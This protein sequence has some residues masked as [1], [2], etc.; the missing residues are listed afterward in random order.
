M[1][2]SL[3]VGV[4]IVVSSCG[5]ELEEGGETSGGMPGL[6]F[7]DTLAAIGSGQDSTDALFR[8]RG[9]AILAD[10]GF[11][12]ATD[13]DPGV[14]FYSDTG[15]L[16]DR[17]GAR[18]LGPA[19]IRTL[20][21]AGLR[22][23]DSV[24]VY[25]AGALRLM[26]FAQDGAFDRSLD[27]PDAGLRGRQPVWFK[28]LEES[29]LLA[30]STGLPEAAMYENQPAR[31]TVR[32]VRLELDGSSSE[33]LAAVANRWWERLPVEGSFSMRADIEGP[34]AVVTAGDSVI[35]LSDN[36]SHTVQ[37]ITIGSRHLPSLTLRFLSERPRATD[38]PEDRGGYYIY[39]MFVDDLGRLW[40]GSSAL[41][42]DGSRRWFVLDRTGEVAGRIDL[43]ETMRM[44]DIN[45][46]TLLM[47]HRGPLDVEHVTLLRLSPASG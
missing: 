22:L 24:I 34:F 4:V 46:S 5:G 15:V 37:R 1:R 18:G 47:Q 16:E 32:V 20:G 2:C 13:G 17:F 3:I 19:E 43:P 12:I 45:G 10:G 28:S 36:T 38:E 27:V 33:E 21:W 7:V 6:Y 39:Q 41:E 42:A 25:D 9:G 44:L 31:D 11:M 26:L 8:V 29:V 30:I 14:R 23:P 40:V 35:Y